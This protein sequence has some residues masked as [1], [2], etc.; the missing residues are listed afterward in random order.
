MP[1]LSSTDGTSLYYE[2]TGAGDPVLFI[3][4]FAGNHRTWAAQMA[5]LG[6]THRCIAYSARGYPPP[7]VPASAV[8]SAP[9][10]SGIRWAPIPRCMSD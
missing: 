2:E 1:Q 8:L 4:E 10:S 6:K 5:A 9:I 7:D 3:H